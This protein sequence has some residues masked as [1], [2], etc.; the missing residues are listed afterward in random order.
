MKNIAIIAAHSETR[1][2]APFADPNWEI[3][4]CSPS[5]LGKVP[6]HEAWF[7]IHS[8]FGETMKDYTEYHR[9]LRTLPL[10]YVRDM[11]ADL[12]GACWYPQD[13]MIA[14]FGPFFFTS[15]MAYMA[16]MA[17]MRN[18]PAIGFWGVQLAIGG[19]YEMQR[20]GCQYFIQKARDRG[21]QVVLPPKSRLLDVEPYGGPEIRGAVT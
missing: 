9:W 2:S 13:E 6:R 14:E 3:W 10:V 1:R 8:P 7:E 11:G 20:P 18:P 16:A 15:S 4:A 19:S 17:I 12:P 5:N 21:I